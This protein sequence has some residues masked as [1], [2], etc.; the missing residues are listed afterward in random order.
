MK[1]LSRLFVALAALAALAAIVAGSAF[2]G[3]NGTQVTHFG[4]LTYTDGAAG[5]VSCSGVHQV[6]KTGSIQ[7][8]ETCKSTT[9]QP[10]SYFQ[11]GQVYPF[12]T[13]F[14]VSDNPGTLGLPSTGGTITASAD[15]MSYNILANY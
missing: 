13:G 15:G 11:P 3:G 4:P 8:S 6:T 12:G 10:V 9:G 1:R 14:W 5:P 2:A 7:E